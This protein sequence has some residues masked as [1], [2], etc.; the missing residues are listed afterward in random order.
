VDW[1][2]DTVHAVLGA[3]IDRLEPSDKRILQAAA[4]VG[5]DFS[6]PWV[7][8]LVDVD[9]VDLAG[10]LRR[11]RLAD[12]IEERRGEG[13]ELR[14]RFVHPLTREVAYQ[15]QLAT[16]RTAGHARLAELL[17]RDGAPP[18]AAALIAH[19]LECAGDSLAAARAWARAA[20]ASRA[21]LADRGRYWR[22]VLELV[23]PLAGD[24]EQRDLELSA[25]VNLLSLG[26]T[27]SLSRD[28]ADHLAR[29]GLEIVEGQQRADVVEALLYVAL[30][31]T[32]LNADSADAYVGAVENALT[33]ARRT[34]W[35]QLIF[36]LEASLAQALTYAGRLERALEVAEHAAANV[37]NA[38]MTFEV[39]G[40]RID[41][42]L[43][44]GSVRSQILSG[45]GRFD[46]AQLELER[47]IAAAN[48][49]QQVELVVVLRLTLARIGWLRRA[50]ADL[51]A[52][53]DE[54]LA[55]A[56]KLGS[57]ANL[58]MAHC[59]AG[60][61]AL[62]GGRQE[63]ALDELGVALRLTEEHGVPREM[64]P[65][66]QSHLAEALREAGHAEEA[67]A[68]AERAVAE[69]HLRALRVFACHAHLEASLALHALGRVDEA[70]AAL[71]DA[72][73][74]RVETGAAGL[75]ERLGDA[76]RLVTSSERRV[77]D[78]SAGA[79]SPPAPRDPDP[80]SSRGAD[81]VD[82]DRG[83]AL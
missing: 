33:A 1:I 32:L 57:T 40:F 30:G 42:A 3:R 4:I 38:G 19:H 11:L 27:E 37:G 70:R 7:R 83:S 35:G 52:Q 6:V 31:R 14:Y 61:A 77:A 48:A 51:G 34:G 68:L 26:W 79:G 10:A 55:V 21:T 43:W 20:V 25:C 62:L 36:G 64:L 45:L 53:V 81:P 16:A 2:P 50:A 75:D 18:Q 44:L 41:P 54:A 49:S 66:I 67:L 29:R 28:E 23:R 59:C 82:S 56:Q 69:A 76:E 17:A 60:I 78:A 72:R 9:A 80:G 58:V 39:A 63:R 24:G 47:V 22:R 15:E 8:A 5:R 71:G 46:A 12:F 13:D 73:A 65:C 74:L